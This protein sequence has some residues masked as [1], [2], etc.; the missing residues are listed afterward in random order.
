MDIIHEI[1]F[2][3]NFLNLRASLDND[4]ERKIND[5]RKVTIKYG[6]CGKTE[7]PIFDCRS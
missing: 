4:D 5:I 7:Y 3:V 1:Y 2:I 6:N